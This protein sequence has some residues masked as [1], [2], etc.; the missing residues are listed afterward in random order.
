MTRAHGALLAGALSSTALYYALHALGARAAAEASLL[1]PAACALALTL[2][3]S[4]D[5]ETAARWFWRL[6]AASMFLW[7]CGQ[8][9]WTLRV[10]RGSELLS[11]GDRMLGPSVVPSV[12]F[13]GFLVPLIAAVALA[14][15]GRPGRWDAVPVAD[16]A[17]LAIGTSFVFAR[18]VFLPFLVHAAEP[19]RGLALGGLCW[20][21]SVFALV[22]WRGVEQPAF[23]RAY[24]GLALYGLVYGV[25]SSLANG[26][27]GP[28]PAAG[29]P[30]D[31]AWI[32]P[33]FLLAFAALPATDSAP[34]R[35]SSSQAVALTAATL[36]LDLLVDRGL[37]GASVLAHDGHLWLLLAAAALLGGVCAARLALEESAEV[38]ARSES[39]ALTQAEERARRLAAVSLLS[40][41]NVV[42]IQ[43]AVDEMF[44]C[45]RAVAPAV[46]E[47]GARMMALAWRCRAIAAE[48]A[49]A[50]SLAPPAARR[51]VNVRQLLEQTAGRAAAEGLA[52]QVRFSSGGLPVVLGD[53]ERLE[54]AFRA[55]MQNAAEARRGGVLRISGEVTP[56]EIVLRFSDD[57]PGIPI[58][59]RHR[60]FDPFFTTRGVR[61]GLGLG[62]TVVEAAVRSHGGSVACETHPA[63]T[64]FVLRL[65]ILDRRRSAAGARRWPL[66]LAAAGSATIATALVV[67]PPELR[68]TVAVLAQLATATVATAALLWTAGRRRG[69]ERAFW[70]L[71]A[72]G[73]AMWA[74][75][76]AVGLVAPG[77]GAFEL[78]AQLLLLE[79][80]GDSLW[81]AALL[82]R[83]DARLRG[84]PRAVALLLIAA[85]LLFAGLAWPA[86]LVLA[87]PVLLPTLP[88]PAL[89][90]ARS[91]SRLVLAVWAAVLSRRSAV[92]RWRASF[93]VLSLMLA[94]W[95]IGASLADAALR[96]GGHLPGLASLGWCAPFLLLAA[97]AAREALRRKADDVSG[98]EPQ[99][100]FEALSAVK[101]G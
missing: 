82:L 45:A 96:R 61:G 5:G 32:V 76:C 52:L 39:I 13:I 86:V 71:L 18:V 44:A 85:A 95:A 99:P 84:R 43:Q 87:L 22:L 72:G 69:R 57:G 6:V 19:Q 92:P 27:G 17:L 2:R 24:G 14:P 23:R 46:G 35:I 94:L 66:A 50:L 55:L 64:C 38:R 79:T 8:W 10:W 54:G 73:P 58:G 7:C 47:R 74:S 75:V 49:G 37:P 25:S 53:R 101:I 26:S 62:L 12:F 15:H 21:L 36:G 83:P 88:M 41:S 31:L 89:L 9:L 34:F 30:L 51:A 3:R 60:V 77:R 68:A 48:L 70:A 59:I 90:A 80:A 28:V 42:E 16:C 29:G 93:K 100:S 4:R 20:A 97:I 63:G 56:G 33:F 91:V 11:F 40:G 1:V 78:V 98:V 81:A 67:S 65:P